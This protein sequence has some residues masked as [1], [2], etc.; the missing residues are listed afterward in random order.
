MSE[1]AATM[2]LQQLQ[3][4]IQRLPPDLVN[5]IAAGEI[6]QRPVSALKEL[7]ENSLDAGKEEILDDGILM[8]PSLVGGVVVFSLFL[9]TFCL[10]PSPY[11]QA[12]RTSTS[13]SERAGSS[14]CRSRTTDAASG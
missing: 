10:S 12:P 4:P 6:V 8:R 3:R 9:I 14:S 7:L 2:H 13:R 11:T 1:R 5:R